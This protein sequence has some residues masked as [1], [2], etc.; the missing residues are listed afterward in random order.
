LSSDLPEPWVPDLNWLEPSELYLSVGSGCEVDRPIFQ[1]DVFVDVPI[2][3]IPK[4]PPTG[5]VVEVKVVPSIVMLVPHPCQC[6]H[7]DSLR[8]YLTL[9]PVT[10]V[11]DYST[12]GLDHTGAKDKFALLDLPTGSADGAPRKSHVANFGRLLSVGKD[13]I[14]PRKR[15]ACLSHM[16]L[17][18]LTKRLLQ[19]QL[20]A[21]SELATVMAFTQKQWNEAFVMQAWV[22]SRGSLKGFTEWMRTETRI[23]ALGDRVVPD[24]YVT[25]AVE[26]LLDEVNSW[27]IASTRA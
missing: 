14:H 10:E 6:Y 18:L 5:T 11:R 8:P 15:V 24:D 12:F 23:A 4:R 27:A 16:G 3:E 2:P 22:R 13:Y 21:P 17:G 26:V 25:G 1:G 9:A 20:R 7:G 19:F